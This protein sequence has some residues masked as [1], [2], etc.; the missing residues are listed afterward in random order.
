[1]WVIKIIKT[2]ISLFYKKIRLD[3]GFDSHLWIFGVS[4]I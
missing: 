4:F 1:M 2:E 3:I